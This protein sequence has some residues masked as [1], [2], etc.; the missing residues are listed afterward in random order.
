M[1]GAQTHNIATYDGPGGQMIYTCDEGASLHAWQLTG[2]MLV[3]KGTN[4]AVHAGHP[5]GMITTSSNGMM[6]GTGIVWVLVGG[7]GLY[8]LDAA[9]ITKPVLW[10]SGMDPMGAIAQVGKFSP[11]IVANG[12]VYA[13]TFGDVMLVYGLK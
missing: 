8:A 7:G 12:N 1:A 9:D 3:D 2:N 13:A 11:P 10:S 5:G 4:A 6:P